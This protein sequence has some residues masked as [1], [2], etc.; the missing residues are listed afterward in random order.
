[1]SARSLKTIVVILAVALSSALLAETRYVHRDVTQSPRAAY[2]E[3]VY[4]GELF[5]GGPNAERF[6]ERTTAVFQADS[7]NRAFLL[8]TIAQRIGMVDKGR[9]Y[10]IAG[11]PGTAGYRDGPGPQALFAMGGRGYPTAAAGGDSKGNLYV[12]DGYNGRIRK[13]TEQ[14]NGKWVVS[15]VASGLATP[16]ALTVDSNDNVW[17]EAWNLYRISPDGTVKNFGAGNPKGLRELGFNSMAADGVGNVYALSREN[18]AAVLWKITQ[19]GQLH[20][21]AGLTQDEWNARS[22]AGKPVPVD[23]PAEEATLHVPGIG[24]V[25]RDG[26]AVYMSGG[27]ETQLRRYKDGRVSSL[28]ADGTWKEIQ[29]RRGGLYIGSLAGYDTGKKILY[30][31]K[32]PYIQID[33]DQWTYFRMLVPVEAPAASSGRSAAR[34]DAACVSIK[35]PASVNADAEFAATVTLRNTGTKAWAKGE[36]PY[37]LGTQDPQDNTQWN[38]QRVELPVNQVKPGQSVTFEIKAKAPNQPGAYPFAWKM[39]EET[40]EWFGQTCAQKIKVSAVRRGA[41]NERGPDVPA[42]TAASDAQIFLAQIKSETAAPGERT[43]IENSLTIA[44]KAGVTTSNYP[45]QIGRPFV[46]GEIKDA[47]QALVD[48]QPIP[49]QADVKERWPDGSVK[50]AILAFLIPKLESRGRVKVTFRNQVDGNKE[51]RLAVKDMLDARFDFDAEM[52]LPNP[53]GHSSASARAMLQAGKFAYWFAGPIATSVIIADHSQGRSFDLGPEAT[54]PLRPIFHATFWPA[55]NKVFVRVIG[56]VANT[57]AVGELWLDGLTLTRGRSKESLYKSGRFVLPMASR[58]SKTFWLG[59][60]PPQ[61]QIDHNLKYLAATKMV[62]NYDSTISVSENSIAANYRAWQA[63]PKDLTQAG[64]WQKAMGTGGGRPD[65]GPYPTWTV[66]WLYT[67]DPRM[68]EMA[69]GNADLCASWPVHYREG[70]HRRA[71]FG[72]VVSVAD[73]PSLFLL[74]VRS[75]DTKPPDRVRIV[76]DPDSWKWNPDISHQPDCVTPQYML[77]GDFWYLEEAWFWAAWSV[78]YSNGAATTSSCGRGPTGKEGGIPGVRCLSMRGQAWAFRNRAQVAAIS[79]DGTPEKAYFEKLTRD[80]IAISEGERGITKTVFENTPEWRWGR[81]VT[82]LPSIPLHFWEPG[83]GN[84]VQEPIDGASAGA[85]I[86]TWE[87]NFLVYALG[88][89]KELGYPTDAL[90]SWLAVNIVGQLTDP[91]YDP[92]LIASYRTAT[93]DRN[94][95]AFRSWAQVKAA[96]KKG[97]DA[98]KEFANYLLNSD[99]GYSLIASTAAAMIANEPKGEDAWDWIYKNAFLPARGTFRDNPKW[100]ILPRRG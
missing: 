55:V 41:V 14:A 27:D 12:T 33:G 61:I 21:L 62:P 13:L 59:G 99:H 1:M 70:D 42:E 63:A 83:N 45:I 31:Y 24:G 53:G 56:E 39:V 86:S 94:G 98:K 52:Q 15:T 6:G 32:Y 36:N 16:T 2:G 54:R 49:T 43:A 10:W 80:F 28:M 8:D 82:G 40:V 77:T 73:R 87:Q 50:H 66:L 97:Y 46:Q 58:W 67:G 23:G 81:N 95:Q 75:N 69:F 89:A 100:A 30:T 20:F 64:N 78:A 17:F 65:I 48:D 19:D 88:R 3:W 35:A 51:A 11:S 79:P 92:Q 72:R 74:N 29:D 71:F 91:T 37:R 60:E 7:K 85:A 90:L 5:D 22:K 76:A 57:E 38:L 44:E 93:V 25:E 18:A 68:R 84:F 96:L 47:P 9:F 34:N 26:S 4:Y